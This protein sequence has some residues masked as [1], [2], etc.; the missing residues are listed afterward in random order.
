MGEDVTLTHLHAVLGAIHKANRFTEGITFE[1]FAGDIR[2]VDA[3]T[4]ALRMAG[5]AMKPIPDSV[6]CRYPSIPWQDMTKLSVWLI[7]QY[8]EIPPEV[9]WNETKQVLPAIESE[10]SRALEEETSREEAA[11]G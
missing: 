10:I 7:H 8:Y 4:Q 11:N 3:T 2:T 1:Q 5:G 9:V 6:R